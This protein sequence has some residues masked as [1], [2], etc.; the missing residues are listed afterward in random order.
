LHAAVSPDGK[1]MVADT[2]YVDCP[3]EKES[4][5]VLVNLQTK[6]SRLLAKINCWADHP[7]HPHPSFSQD[8]KKVVFTYADSGNN[9]RVG[10]ID[11]SGTL[12]LKNRKCAPHP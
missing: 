5:I 9:L 3:V 4:N 7:G 11:I 1:L 2:R 8:S 12:Y 6:K 10:Y